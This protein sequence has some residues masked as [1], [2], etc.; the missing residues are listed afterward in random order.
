MCRVQSAAL[1]TLPRTALAMVRVGFASF[2]ECA[3]GRLS[4]IHLHPVRPLRYTPDKRQLRMSKW[5]IIDLKQPLMLT[6]TIE[7][8]YLLENNI[9][10]MSAGNLY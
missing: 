1:D 7:F 6:P 2:Q 3:N 10:T 8:G 4:G 5:P 9:L